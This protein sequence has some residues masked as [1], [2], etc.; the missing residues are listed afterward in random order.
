MTAT[1]IALACLAAL[2]FIAALSSIFFAAQV[3]WPR[4]RS[5]ADSWRTEVEKGLIPEDKYLAWGQR[6]VIVPSPK[7]YSMVGLWFPLADSRKTVIIVHGVTYTRWGSI[8]YLPAFRDRGFNVLAIDQRHHGESGGR[9][10]TFGWYERDDMKAWMDWAIAET[11]S[12][13]IV[14]THGE[15]MGAAVVLQHA[16]IDPR[17]AFV[18]ADCPFSDLR[19]LLACRLKADFHLPAFPLLDMAG[20]AAF[21]LTG[22]MRFKR[23][24]P[25]DCA[26]AIAA[27][28]MFAHGADDDY[29]PPQMSQE[30]FDVR[31]G[32]PRRLYIAPGAKH[33]EAL[34][35]DPV[36][37]DRQI[38]A[39]LT[40][41]DLA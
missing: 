7:G 39:F 15:S 24:R 38:G 36:E 9:N 22:G 16:A 17:V 18:V 35:I 5:L 20:L 2:G 21:V 13:A 4:R 19:R 11:G 1:N 12:G 3:I 26:T 27:P 23:I 29:I 8:K 10:S 34:F 37:Y 32:K 6:R 31:E 28:V 25:I 41:N 14:G 33:A 40:E 30:M